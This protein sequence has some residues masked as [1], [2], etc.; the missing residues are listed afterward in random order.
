MCLLMRN[1]GGRLG[2]KFHRHIL[3]LEPSLLHMDT[4]IL[5]KGSVKDS[6]LVQCMI[7]YDNA[8]DF[9]RIDLLLYCLA[10]LEL[11]MLS[12]SVLQIPAH[13]TKW[14]GVYFPDMFTVLLHD[15]PR[16]VALPSLM[17]VT[18]L[19]RPGLEEGI[20]FRWRYGPLSESGAS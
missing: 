12:A 18:K 8:A 15:S 1:S 10:R 7:S 17:L 19:L 14:L 16:Q 9:F 5:I 3:V 13:L 20:Q 11:M 6:S 2:G 4:S